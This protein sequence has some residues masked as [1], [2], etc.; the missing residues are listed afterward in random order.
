MDRFDPQTPQAPT[1]LV[2][3]LPQHIHV[4][5][6]AHEVVGHEELKR[7][8]IIVLE[9]HR[10]VVLHP[11]ACTRA[12]IWRMW[13]QDRLS[14]TN[15]YPTCTHVY[16]HTSKRTVDREHHVV[17]LQV[18]G[19]VGPPRHIYHQAAGVVAWCVFVVGV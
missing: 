9:G 15:E 2:H 16:I 14:K 6:V 5:E 8:K 18:L 17:L 3:L 1:H 10:L 12:S 13:V 4:D 19:R 7:N 11:V